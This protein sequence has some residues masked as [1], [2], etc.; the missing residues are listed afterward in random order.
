MAEAVTEWHTVESEQSNAT[1]EG[2]GDV[3][4]LSPVEDGNG[5]RA[6]II[7][8][9]RKSNNVVGVPGNN[10]VVCPR[11]YFRGTRKRMRAP[12]QR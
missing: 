6:N 4:N 8:S 9:K 11:P 5:R 10:K 1:I 2:E 7:R 12:G 3:T